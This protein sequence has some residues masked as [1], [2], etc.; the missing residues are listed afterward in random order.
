MPRKRVVPGET[1]GSLPLP[2]KLPLQSRSRLL[3]SALVEACHTILENEG[4]AAMTMNRLAE[5]SGVAIG[6]I[7]QYFPNKEAIVT[8][9][10]EHVLEEEAS[11][12]VP[13]LARRIEGLPLADCLREI[14]DNMLRIE[15]RLF[16]LNRE[17]HLK[18]YSQL[19]AGMRTGEFQ[20]T[21]EYLDQAWETFIQMYAPQL[22]DKARQ[23]AAYMLGIGLRSMTRQALEDNP[24]LVT[25]AAFRD[26]LVSM[27][28]ACLRP[29]R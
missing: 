2:R 22:D 13:A 6:S 16:R 3:V 18:Y 24:E 19:Q 8:L 9:A 10:F 7:Y 17:F 12:N 29:S 21:R 20:S 15:L 5:V 27:A 25:R 26:C 28:L 23:A 1:Q 11:I 4:A 14:Y